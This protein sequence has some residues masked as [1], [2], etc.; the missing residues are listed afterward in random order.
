MLHEALEQMENAGTLPTFQGVRISETCLARLLTD[1]R[2]LVRSV[3]VRIVGHTGNR[4]R[5]APGTARKA[6][7]RQSMSRRRREAAGG[8][9]LAATPEGHTALPDPFVRCA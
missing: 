5:V 9:E 1:R 4:I 8:E 2:G 3:A 7:A 6:T